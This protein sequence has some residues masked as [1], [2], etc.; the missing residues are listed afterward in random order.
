VCHQNTCLMPATTVEQLIHQLESEGTRRIG[1]GDPTGIVGR[2][3]T[4]P[5]VPEGKVSE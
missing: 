4:T 3:S 2:A 5:G 1:K